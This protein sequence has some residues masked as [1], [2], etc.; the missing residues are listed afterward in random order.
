MSSSGTNTPSPEPWMICPHS[1]SSW[2]GPV[3]KCGRCGATT[4]VSMD[5]KESKP[6]FPPV[7]YEEPANG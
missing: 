1:F 4:V 7:K 5:P 2:F 6:I 3:L